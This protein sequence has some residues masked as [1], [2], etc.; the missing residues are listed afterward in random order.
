[1][2]V[3]ATFYVDWYDFGTIR[4]I[5]MIVSLLALSKP[6]GLD[7]PYPTIVAE[8]GRYES[9]HLLCD[10]LVGSLILLDS[11]KD[12]ILTVNLVSQL[13]RVVIFVV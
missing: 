10:L 5:L 6:T 4:V 13:A 7:E 8:D 2:R 12:A 1:M 9:F 11:L 3:I